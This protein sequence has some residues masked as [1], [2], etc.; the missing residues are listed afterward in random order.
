V[1]NPTTHV[2]WYAAVALT[3][4]FLFAFLTPPMQTP[5][6]VAH[7][8]RATAIAAGQLFPHKVDG[9]PS[10]MIPADA[11]DLV[12]HTWME[13]AGK[14]VQYERDRFARARTLRPSSDTVRLSF[15]AF[16]TCVPYVPQALAI[17]LTRAV[18]MPTLYSFY[19]GRIANAL[20]GVLLVMLAMR[21]AP[22]AAWIFAAVGLTPMFVYLCGSFSAD[23]VTIGVAFCTIAA[24]LRGSARLLAIFAPILTLAKPA[25]FLIALVAATVRK[26]ATLIV[27]ALVIAG[28]AI[29]AWTTRQAYYPMRADVAT[30]APQQ[31][32]HVKRAPFRFV[33]L[34]AKDYANN[35]D[36]YY[37][38][39]TGRLGWLDIGLPRFVRWMFGLLFLYVA[40]SAAVQLSVQRRVLFV[41][42]F[43]G[44][45]LVIS[46]SQYL[47][48]TAVG[49]GEIHG[50]QGRYFLPA[51]PLLL[52]AISR[53]WIP[54]HAAVPLAAG[55][56]ANVV[57]LATLA[58]RYYG[59]FPRL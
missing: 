43:L 2:Y 58:H 54:F 24:G 48:W 14:E 15:P 33:A 20:A 26:K 21:L 46:L 22:A 18:K 35:I 28:V 9:K 51:A 47:I 52:L 5:D 19:A 41:A 1:R 31:L 36:A 25:Y 40:A 7:Y 17:A 42:L 8:W 32:E 13:M 16:Y 3:A 59:T 39:F 55:V 11:R 34:A 30:D 12:F 56:V 57:A 29:A 6:E 44:T 53:R 4:A 27:L 23:V 38:H 49:A 37:E 10:A 45:L 50:I